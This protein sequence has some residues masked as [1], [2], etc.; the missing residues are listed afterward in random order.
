MSF[1]ELTRIKKRKNRFSENFSRPFATG[2]AIHETGNE[3]EFGG[4]QVE[5]QLPTIAATAH[6]TNWP[7]S[8]LDWIVKGYL[9]QFDFLP[10]IKD[11]LL[12]FYLF[13]C[14]HI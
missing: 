1:S 2:N 13:L 12:G 9:C 6:S 10:I 7:P 11:F 8:S 3:L 5:L 14:F 4:I